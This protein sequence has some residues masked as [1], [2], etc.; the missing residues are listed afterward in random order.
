MKSNENEIV[1]FLANVIDG[2]CHL[3]REI[4]IEQKIETFSS[5]IYRV[6]IERHGVM[7]AVANLLE[8]TICTNITSTTA[9]KTSQNSQK[10]NFITEEML[11]ARLKLKTKTTRTQHTHTFGKL[12]NRFISTKIR[13]I[14]FIVFILFGAWPEFT[15]KHLNQIRTCTSPL[16]DLRATILTGGRFICVYSMH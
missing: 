10:L 12:F 4:E 14:S 3:V 1:F 5:C 2:Y 7:V 8:I 11:D 13:V 15:F 6:D 9:K 16:R